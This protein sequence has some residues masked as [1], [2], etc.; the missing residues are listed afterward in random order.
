MKLSELAQKLGADL[1]NADGAL[2]SLEITGI[3]PLDLAKSGQISFLTNPKWAPKLKDTKASAV[4]LSA[5]RGDLNIP[6]I[7]HK[8]AYAAMA[9]TSGLFHPRKPSYRGQSELAIVHPE[10][11]V[12]PEATLYPFAVVEKGVKVAARA[13]IYPHCFLGENSEIGED[14]VLFPSCVVMEGCKVGKRVLVHACTVI[15]GDGFGF[16]PTREGIEKIPQVGGVVIHDDV[17]LGPGNSIDRGAFTDTVIGRGCKFD[18]QVH[19]AHGVELGEFSMIAGGA[20]IAGGAKT[21]KRFMMAGHA[22]LGPGLVMGDN[23]VLGPKCGMTRS[24][25]EPGEY[26]GLP[27][28]PIRNWRRQVVAYEH[29]PELV[30][31]VRALEKR[32]AALDGGGTG[33]TKTDKDGIQHL[34]MEP[35]DE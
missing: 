14:T 11:D 34:E 29:L 27:A 19:I 21:G 25:S 35:G 2:A 7:I 23:I 1:V 5:P 10:A 24:T 26:M 17:E 18:S 15:G 9:I 3:A 13:V 22:A 8:N 16:A 6:Q 32:L 33:A 12:H 30:K 20:A 31:T 4:I 28:I